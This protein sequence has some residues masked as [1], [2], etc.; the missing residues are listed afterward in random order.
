[1]ES[2]EAEIKK[3]VLAIHQRNGG[4]LTDFDLNLRLLDPLLLLDSLDL[5]ETMVAIERKFGVSPFDSPEPPRAWSDIVRSV[6]SGEGRPAA[7]EEDF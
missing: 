1:M 7:G 5:A 2:I 6:K 4:G 3:M